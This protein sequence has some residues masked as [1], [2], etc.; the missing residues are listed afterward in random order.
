LTSRIA[1]E[2]LAKPS[3][4]ITKPVQG[5]VAIIAE[6]ILL[7]IVIVSLFVEETFF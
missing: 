1:R 5:P 3:Y 6:E 2:A 4:F 7:G